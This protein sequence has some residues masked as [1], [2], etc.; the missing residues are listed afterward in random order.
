MLDL[1]SKL[2]IRCTT[3]DISL[4]KLHSVHSV[5]LLLKSWVFNADLIFEDLI[6][7]R[8]IDHEGIFKKDLQ[9]QNWRFKENVMKF[10]KNHREVGF[11]IFNKLVC[12]K[13]TKKPHSFLKQSKSKTKA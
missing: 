10:L 6:A 2:K 5:Q 13:K 12:K 3:L 11:Y 8:N 9:E 1:Q 7:L 4:Y